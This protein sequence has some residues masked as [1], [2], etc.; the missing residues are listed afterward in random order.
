MTSLMSPLPE[1]MA[2]EPDLINK[3]LE[4]SQALASMGQTFR[5]SITSGSFS[6]SLD[7]REATTKVV[8]RKQKKKLSPSQMRRKQRRKEDFL[9][10]KSDPPK[11]DA[12]A[13]K[14]SETNHEKDVE[15][16]MM[17][18][19]CSICEKTF[20]SKV[21]LKI[22][23]GKSHKRENLRSTSNEVSP[24][25]TSPLKE[26]PRECECCGEVMSPNHQCEESDEEEPPEGDIVCG[27]CGKTYETEEDMA[28]HTRWHTLQMMFSIMKTSSNM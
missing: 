18:N 27:T 15:K 10:K 26:I 19:N 23:M 2:Q 28:G 3:C 17:E 9:R 14:V 25:E 13:E 5:L 21:G 7:T 20:E 11:E 24:I 8:E 22:H 16:T 6:Y 4:F 1:K 12:T